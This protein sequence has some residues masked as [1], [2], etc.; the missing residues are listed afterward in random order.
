MTL[1]ILGRK[2]V[3][4]NDFKTMLFDGVLL[5]IAEEMMKIL[6]WLVWVVCVLAGWH[7]AVADE[8]ALKPFR[9]DSYRQILAESAHAPLLLAIWSVDCPSCLKDMKNLRALHE[10]HPE[11]KIVMLAVDDGEA[12]PEIR[13]IIGDERLAALDNWVFADENPEKLRYEI[14]PAWFGELPRTYFFDAAHRRTG[15]SGALTM[16]E[17]EA[18]LAK[19][20]H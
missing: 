16:D 17:F 12:L 14:D 7:S 1:E 18:E 5:R 9:I 11:L 4:A 19:L 6:R 8:I 10:K 2:M 20:K 3:A 15:K 13:R